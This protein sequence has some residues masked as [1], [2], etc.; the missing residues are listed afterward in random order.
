DSLLENEFKVKGIIE[1]WVNYQVY[2]NR[3]IILKE[4]LNRNEIVAFIKSRLKEEQGILYV[5]DLQQLET[6]QVQQ[7]IKAMLL[8]GFNESLSGDIQYILKPQWFENW[9][10]GTNHGAW[11]P[12]DSHIPLIF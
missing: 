6:P 5:V 9:S 2:L 7:N 1:K 10:L 4:N 3:E 8:N 12:Y 11:N